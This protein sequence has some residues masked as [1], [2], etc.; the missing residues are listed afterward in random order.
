MSVFKN[1]SVVF[2]AKDLE[3]ISIGSN[4]GALSRRKV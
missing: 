3:E 2:A 1:H 4:E